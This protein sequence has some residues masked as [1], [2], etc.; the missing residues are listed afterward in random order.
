MTQPQAGETIDQVTLQ[1]VNNYLVTT[2]RE[3]GIAMR[4][5]AYSPLF[6]EG[7]DFSCAIFDRDGEMIGQAE[8]CPAQLGAII[9][10]VAWTIHE[11]GVENFHEGDIVLHNDPFRGGCHLPEYCVIKPVFLVD[12]L[13]GFVS[14]IGHMTEV[15]GKVP[16][17]FPGDATEVFQEGVR[18]PP[19]K[20]VDRGQDVEA[21]WNIIL[22][23]VRTPKVSY[24]DMMAMIGSLYVGE[25]RIVELAKKYGND[26]LL[27]ITEAIKDYSERRMRAEIAEMP[28]GVYELERWVAD[29][30]GI[31]REPAKV[32]VTVTIGGDRMTVDFTGSDAQRKGPINCTYGVTASATYN[33]LMHLTDSSIPSNHGCYRSVR[34]IAPPRTIVNV[35]YPGASVGGNSEIQPHL[36]DAIFG[37]LAPA[38][39]DR[40]P[41]ECGGTNSLVS[42]GGIHP[43]TGEPFA[44][45]VNEG[46]GWGGRPHADGNNAL[47][48]YVGNCGC[49]PVEILETRYPILHES[50]RIAE[51]SAGAG[52]N[53]GGFGSIREFRVETDELR[54]SAFVERA[55]IRPYGLFGGADGGLAGVEIARSGSDYA[56]PRES[57]GVTCNG[58]FSDV[59]LRWGDRIRSYCSGGAGYGSPLERDL[60][61]IEED[62]REGFISAEQAAEQYGVVFDTDGSIDAAA[63]ERRR[64]ELCRS[65]A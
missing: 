39:P 11:I 14:S 53:R 17:G 58:K 5:T 40:V 42:F 19:V 15:G 51:G 24:G 44:S 26:R 30:D 4:N 63:T 9:Y 60:G 7:L 45:L 22:A 36:V 16:G 65:T 33:A 54:V 50:F 13:V 8:F 43:D 32:K 62:V 18:I 47:C 52:R 29:D 49:Q 3:M 46:C 59:H 28:D 27:E 38:L 1:V 10:V 64:A 6:N 37:A 25:R 48:Q 31:T 61:R 21:V 35:E 2:A 12:E 41:A 57:A 55:V 23:N 56:P 34:I 20:I